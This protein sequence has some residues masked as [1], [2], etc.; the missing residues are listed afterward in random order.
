MRKLEENYINKL[1]DSCFF[2]EKEIVDGRPTSEFTTVEPINP[3][4]HVT[5]V[6]STN[7]LN[8]NKK[9]ILELIDSLPNIEEG[10][11]LEN[12]YF[13]KE[14]NKWCKDIKIL[15]K[16]IN[17]AMACEAVSCTTTE[18]DSEIITIVKRTKE[19]DLL[20]V[21]G[22][23]P[24]VLPTKSNLPAKG[25]TEQEKKLIAENKIRITKELKYYNSIINI[26]LGFYGIHAIITTE[27]ENKIDFYDQDNNLLHSR[28]FEDTDG[29]IGI[30]AMLDQRLKCEFKDT[31]GNTIMYLV[32]DKRHI[33]LLS[34]PEGQKYGYRVE[35]TMGNDN[36]YERICIKTTN[37]NDDYVI[38]N[39]NIDS[40]DLHVELD[41]Q[42]GPYGNYV[43]GERRHFWYKD[44]KISGTCLLF[45]TEDE[46]RLK[47]HHLIGDADGIKIDNK[48]V[49][50]GLTNEQFYLLSTQI[51][52]HPRNKEMIVYALEE[53]DK[54][55]PGIK[56][57]VSNHFPLYN[58]IVNYEDQPNI[59]V[60]AIIQ[61]TIH[62][63]CNLKN[64]NPPKV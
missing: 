10:N 19:K 54:Q 42:F 51:A 57:F 24:E 3:E 11:S 14:H 63:K 60:D 58:F 37:A 21:K 64:Y 4:A 26:G 41:N 34:A 12:L 40:G 23:N 62:P 2:E 56:D 44:T 18:I 29:I 6:F 27:N 49:V 16:L 32:D 48:E 1:F 20:E 31:F 35:I 53:I 46:W 45:M 28:I 59:I 22:T 8:Q 9:A 61:A 13:D 43:D 50:S 36:N 7:K 17:M 52:R 47:G 15:D 55:L 30:E 33:F 39:I 5:I 38:K 25:Y